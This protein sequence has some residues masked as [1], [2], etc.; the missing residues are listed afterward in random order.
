M[1][2]PNGCRVA[3]GNEGIS[4]IAAACARAMWFV[5]YRAVHS[6]RVR[7]GRCLSKS[8]STL[9]F[10]YWSW[11]WRAWRIR[12][13]PASGCYPQLRLR[14][15]CTRLGGFR[16]SRSAH[17][18]CS[19]PAHGNCSRDRTTLTGSSERASDNQ[20]RQAADTPRQKAAQNT[21]FF[22]WQLPV[23]ITEESVRNIV[24]NHSVHVWAYG[25][26][27][28]HGDLDLSLSAS[29]GD[30][31][32][33]SRCSRCRPKGFERPRHGRALLFLR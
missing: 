17:S 24:E 18:T 14:H 27:R 30:L 28:Y 19:N 6:R 9:S 7:P 21:Q 11:R 23:P 12:D 32:A 1:A 33:K 31:D 25:F 10:R 20:E 4:A 8:S 26:I 15:S 3:S 2:L 13:E 16:Q 22:S 29:A 5:Q